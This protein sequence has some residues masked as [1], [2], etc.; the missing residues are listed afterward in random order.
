MSSRGIRGRRLLLGLLVILLVAVVPS[1]VV[2][3]LA[4][5]PGPP[6]LPELGSVPAFNLTDERGQPFTQAALDGNV[7][8]VNFIFT[9]CDTICPL[10][11]GR[12]EKIQEKTGVAGA[13]IKMVSFTVD[14]AYDTPAQLA[15]FAK[16]YHADPA[17]WRF[18][19]GTANDMKPIVEGAFWNS[20]D[21]EGTRASGAPSI[22]HNGHF[23]LVDGNRKIR[24]TYDSAD[25]RRLDDLLRDARYLLRTS[26]I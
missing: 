24:G 6:E 8:I 7:T 5:R 21:N 16:R 9:R 1:V 3:T 10:I 13:A 25:V 4:C 26:T 15:E 17:R 11:S 20:M 19:T 2:P 12:M 18:V 23:I 14:P 22:A